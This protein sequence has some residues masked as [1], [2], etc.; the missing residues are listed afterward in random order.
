MYRI[1]ASPFDDIDEISDKVLKPL[2]TVKDFNDAEKLH[3]WC[4]N[5]VDVCEDFYADYFQVQ[6]DNLLLYRGIQW[7]AAERN[8]NRQ[9]DRPQTAQGRSP[10]I[11]INHLYDFTEQW[12]SR[13]TRYRPVV[14]VYPGKADIESQNE[15]KISHGVLDDIWY[16][17]NIDRH[18]QE[19]VRYIKIFGEGYLFNLWN[20]NKGDLH[21]DWAEA[22][23]R[24]DRVAVL[25]P[26]GLPVVDS[27]SGDPLLLQQAVR[28]GDVEYINV[29]P[30]HVFDQPCRDRDKIEWTI[31]WE[32]VDVEYLKAKYPEQADKIQADGL[33]NVFQGEKFKITKMKN[34][35]VVYTVYHPPSEFLANGRYV[36]FIRSNGVILENVDYPYSHGKLPYQYMADIDVP[37]QIR[38]MSFFQ[39][40]QP[41]THQI[42]A[43]ASLIYKALVLFAHPKIVAPERSIDVAQLLNESTAMFYSGGVP[44]SLM[45][46]HP[47]TPELFSYMQVLEGLADKISGIFTMSRGEAPSGVRA[48][49]AL[50]VLEEQEDKRSYITAI[51]YNELGIV[52]NAK[53]TLSIAGDYYD[54]TDGRLLRIVGKNNAYT[55]K[56]FKAANLSKPYD[57][58]VENTTAL[59]QS[60][61]ARIE[62]INEINAIPV[63][64]DSVFSKGQ[65]VSALN[66]T[67]SEAFKDVATRAYDCAA[68]ENEDFAAGAPVADP[69][70]QEDLITHWQ[71]HQQPMQSREYKELWPPEFKAAAE[72][73]LLMTEYLM[74]KRA[75]G[76]ISPLGEVL[77]KGNP[78][79]LSKLQA[80]CPDF[81]IL[82]TQPLDPMPMMGMP[83][84]G[85]GG[86]PPPGAPPGAMGNTLQPEPLQSGAQ[87]TLPPPD[88]AP[89]QPNPNG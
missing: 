77:V 23:R 54:D 47:V 34:E 72:R 50:R 12:V 36:K 44:P 62:E 20:P 13:I 70:P 71:T 2:W 30:W 89:A 40:L 25:G 45:T 27:T 9:L 82:L 14:A 46:Q 69:V 10:R 84:M 49:K 76:V 58:R 78:V 68:S 74:W 83:P 35:V 53:M 75:Y 65:I 59:S 16:K 22:S 63:Q 79:F 3:E 80:L 8:L 26:D 60:P 15:A 57:I 31:T 52:S 21:P 51:K 19:W 41:I 24:G 32:T 17:N 66:L 48:A 5:A 73:H 61:A 18:L 1:S 11:V 33:A 28:I 81:P 64:P 67:A 86:M 88:V 56:S 6:R 37:D 55:I 7:I 38:G 87:T 85:G 4:V 42:N 39:Q 29:A 43:V